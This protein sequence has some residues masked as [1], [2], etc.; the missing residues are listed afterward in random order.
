M[1]KLYFYCLFLFLLLVTTGCSSDDDQARL[2]DQ[3]LEANVNGLEFNAGVN[4]ASLI[5]TK[6]IDPA[7]RVNLFVRAISGEGDIMEFMIENFQGVGKYYFGNSFYNN[8][9]IK[10]ERPSISEQWRIETNGALNLNSNFIEITL[11]EDD[12]IEGRISCKELK[13]T[14][15]DIFGEVDG[16][17]RLRYIP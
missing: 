4:V 17:F 12:H 1:K 3:Y 9:W 15:E 13:N 2:S 5:F 8:S 6:E 10:Y 11:N 7:G 14:L 16:D